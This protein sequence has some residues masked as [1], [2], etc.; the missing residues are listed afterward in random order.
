MEYLSIKEIEFIILKRNPQAQIIS[1]EN[2]IKHFKNSHQFSQS[3]PGNREEQFPIHFMKP[4]LSWHK[5]QTKQ[6]KK[7]KLQTNVTYEYGHKNF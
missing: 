4:V 7:R 5:T 3:L 2:S 6:Y 1:L